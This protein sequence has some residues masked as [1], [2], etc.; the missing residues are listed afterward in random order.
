MILPL[1]PMAQTE[2]T[3]SSESVIKVSGTSTMHD[4]E[5]E[6]EKANGSANF[7]IESG[8]LEALEEINVVIPVKSLKSGK[9]KMDNNAYEALKAEDH[10]RIKFKLD[11]TRKLASNSSTYDLSVTGRLTIA[12]ETRTMPLETTC[13]IEGNSTITCEGSKSFKM[14]KFDVEPPSVMWGTITTGDEVTVEYQVKFSKQ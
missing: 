2:W 1:W 14:S 4:W 10:P 5:M 13:S 12:G 7:T 8:E 9:S 6:S 11:D 3:M